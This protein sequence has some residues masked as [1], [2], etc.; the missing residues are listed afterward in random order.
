MKTV[1]KLTFTPLSRGRFRCNQKNLIT[2]D[3]DR[4]RRVYGSRGQKPQQKILEVIMN[5]RDVWG[6]PDCGH[7]NYFGVV[8]KKTTCARCGKGVMVTAK[9]YHY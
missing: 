1:E 5:W 8:G 9:R 3:C 4:I 2:K 6:C 7:S